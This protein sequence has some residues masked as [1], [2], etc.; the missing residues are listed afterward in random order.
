MAFLA[1]I[2]LLLSSGCV[3]P[4]AP[5][6]QS[7]EVKPPEAPREMPPAEAPTD[8]PDVG[9]AL[10]FAPD[11]IVAGEEVKFSIFMSSGRSASGGTVVIGIEKA[12][13]PMSTMA[14]MG[15]MVGAVEQAP[16]Q[17]ALGIKFDEEGDYIIHAH[18]VPA[19]RSMM[20]M[21]RNHADFG[22]MRVFS[23][24]PVVAAPMKVDVRIAPQAYDP[25]VKDDF[26]PDTLTVAAGT[27]VTWRNEDVSSHTV[28]EDENNFTSPLI[29]PG[30]SWSYTFNETG[31]YRYHCNPH[32]WMEGTIIVE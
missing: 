6:Q 14:M 16:G 5:Q 9:I 18:F 7:R 25:D 26:V 31:V 23:E 2:F 12:T 27:T 19:G 1:T 22:P 20:E 10:T 28:T 13:T 17:Y 11:P 32:P 30:G 3:S 15:D 8:K 29:N 21:M 4:L 24:V